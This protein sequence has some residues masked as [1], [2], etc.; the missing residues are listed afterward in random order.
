MYNYVY[1]LGS[2]GNILSEEREDV[3]YIQMQVPHVIKCVF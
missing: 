2:A 1:Y 3:H